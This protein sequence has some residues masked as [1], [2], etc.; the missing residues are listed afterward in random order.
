[1]DVQRHLV[2]EPVTAAPPS[3]GDPLRKYVRRHRISVLAASLVLA[4]LLVGILGTSDGMMRA[5]NERHRAD[6]EA[7]NARLAADAEA[8]ARVHAEAI[9]LRAVNET[10]R[11]EQELARATE[12]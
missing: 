7:T 6:V 5:L 1:M 8:T 2:G 4:A 11:A 9:G 12:S 3:E 10:Q